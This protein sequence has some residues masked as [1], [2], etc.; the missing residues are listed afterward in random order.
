MSSKIYVIVRDVIRAKIVLSA[1][2]GLSKAITATAAYTA[3]P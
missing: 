2:Q 1:A 3:T